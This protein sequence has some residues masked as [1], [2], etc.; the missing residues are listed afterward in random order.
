MIDSDSQKR[1][2]LGTVVFT[3]IVGY[4]KC[5]VNQQID[6]KEHF[7]QLISESIAATVESERVVIDTGDGIAL[8]FLG[9][10][11][12]A[13]VSSMDLRAEVVLQ[14]RGAQIPYEVRTGINVGPVRLVTDINGRFNVLG[15][16][17]N[18]AQRVMSFASPNQVLASRAFYDVVWCLSDSYSNLFQY[19]GVR[20]DK[21]ERE[22]VLYEVITSEPDPV[23]IGQTQTEPPPVM[24]EYTRVIRSRLANETAPISGASWDAEVLRRIE[25][26]LM[27]YIGPLAKVVVRK[28]AARAMSLE[29]LQ[30]RIAKSIPAGE[31]RQ[32]YMANISA[33]EEDSEDYSS[34]QTIDLEP[35]LASWPDVEN[36]ETD[37]SVKWSPE[38]LAILQDRLAEFVGPLAAMLV[39]KASRR[40]VD[41][42]D[43]I[44]RLAEEIDDPN[45]RDRFVRKK[46]GK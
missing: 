17:I 5:P 42:Q 31:K 39:R 35:D 32:S 4:S 20:K 25:N 29:D 22:H 10:P 7:N 43:L 18:V 1:N 11:E 33:G 12:H 21:H 6:I 8:C 37:E 38:T 45:D 36:S 15:D 44:K 14:S 3:D 41:E 24:E 26:E 2:W 27:L 23:T 13:I 9:D 46:I 40:A 19:Y 28:E 34:H 30:V 16:G